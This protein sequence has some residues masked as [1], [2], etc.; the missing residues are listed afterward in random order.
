MRVIDCVPQ[1][2]AR[3]VQTVLSRVQSWRR[4]PCT[5]RSLKSDGGGHGR[6]TC[7]A[8][9]GNRSRFVCTYESGRCTLRAPRV[10][11]FIG[12][13]THNTTPEG[14]RC[15]DRGLWQ[16]KQCEVSDPCGR[17]ALVRYGRTDTST[18]RWKHVVRS[19]I[20]S[21]LPDASW[22]NAA[23]TAVTNHARLV[24]A[25]LEGGLTASVPECAIASRAR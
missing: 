17:C 5:S 6:S 1:A 25:A 9:S 3:T 15:L 12:R 23:T 7:R 19:L 22:D 10:V 24:A 20:S 4:A 8:R 14:L 16:M 21:L 13:V 11:H 2:V 18:R